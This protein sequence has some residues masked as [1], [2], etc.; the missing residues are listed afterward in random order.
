MPQIQVVSSVRP[1]RGAVA[2]P[3]ALYLFAPGPITNLGRRHTGALLRNV[4]ADRRSRDLPAGRFIAVFVVNGQARA[5]QMITIPSS[6]Q[7]VIAMSDHNIVLRRSRFGRKRRGPVRR[8]SP[9]LRGFADVEELVEEAVVEEPAATAN[10][11]GS[12]SGAKM[13]IGL[14]ALGLLGLGLYYGLTTTSPT[15]RRVYRGTV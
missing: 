8:R 15:G 7:Y 6:G 13:A 5:A 1:S 2:P 14:G 4:P 10:G 11:N 12:G 3:P 9:M